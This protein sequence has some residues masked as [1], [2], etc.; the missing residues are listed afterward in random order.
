[1]VNGHLGV[2][3]SYSN[4]HLQAWKVIRQ[5]RTNIWSIAI[6]LHRRGSQHE[7]EEW[8]IRCRYNLACRLQGSH[9]E[10]KERP[11]NLPATASEVAC[12]MDAFWMRVLERGER[13]GYRYQWRVLRRSPVGQS[14][15]H[16]ASAAG[17]SLEFREHREYRPGDDLRHLDWHASARSDRLLV[18]VFEQ[19]LHPHLELILD[20]SRSMDL[21]ESEKGRAALGLTAM[22]AAA[23]ENS[24]FSYR[25]FLLQERCSMLAS[26]SQAP[27]EWPFS[28][29]TGHLSAGEVLLRDTPPWRPR[30][31]RV[32]VSDLFWTE[33]PQFILAQLT[34]QPLWLCWCRFWQ[35]KTWRHPCGV[36]YGW[37]ISK[38]ATSATC[39]STKRRWNVIALVW[40]SISNNGSG[41]VGRQEQHWCRWLRRNSS[42]IGLRERCCRQSFCNRV[43][44]NGVGS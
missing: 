1:M 23:A 12:V 13:E 38:R 15:R 35:K 42:R 40:S 17:S 4:L 27:T 26:G 25:L 7:P 2:Y 20:G 39:W 5:E 21:P 28:G 31:V 37:W 30:S 6:A 18:K 34:W 29:F 36:R 14:D 41:P 10:P 9:R 24:G 3:L 16:L 19:E 43:K 32:L 33:D 44:A 8:A 22:L 11:N